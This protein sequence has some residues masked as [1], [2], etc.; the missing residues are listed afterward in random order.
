MNFMN[1]DRCFICNQ[2]FESKTQT[3]GA[4]AAYVQRLQTNYTPGDEYEY[5]EVVTQGRGVKVCS[6]ECARQA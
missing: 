2:L 4:A 1:F 5:I 3:R 6:D